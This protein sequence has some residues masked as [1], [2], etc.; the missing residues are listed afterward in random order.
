MITYCT[1]A[2]PGPAWPPLAT[3]ILCFSW[4]PFGP[5]VVM[6]IGDP[7]TARRPGK[8]RGF[9]PSG[10]TGTSTATW[11]QSKRAAFAR[12]CGAS[13]GNAPFLWHAFSPKLIELLSHLASSARSAPRTAEN[14]ARGDRGAVTDT[15]EAACPAVSGT[16][17]R[18]R[19]SNQIRESKLPRSGATPVPAIARLRRTQ[20]DSPELK[21]CLPKS[22]RESNR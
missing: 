4:A 22:G 7:G 5:M 13:R 12:K 1:L 17:E 18:D 16:G 19:R 15:L 3:R 14:S 2:L 9:T 21:I 8:S 10:C 11:V 6:R 20:G